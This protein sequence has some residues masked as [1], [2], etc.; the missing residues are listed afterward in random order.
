[1][2]QNPSTISRRGLI[3]GLGAAGGAI[4][5]G[6]VAPASAAPASGSPRSAAAAPRP[7]MQRDTP[8][9]G[10]APISSAPQF[11]VSYQ[12]RC[13][14]DFFPE[15]DLAYGRKFG[16]GGFYTNVNDDY[17]AATF[18]L[19]PGATLYDL[20]WYVSNSTVMN[21]Y[22]NV[23]ASNEAIL[24]T[25]WST[26]VPAGSGVTAHRFVIPSTVNG[27]YPHGTRLMVAAG[28]ATNG[29]TLINGVRAG[30]KNAP[31][32]PVLLPTPVRAYDSR[33]AD[34][35]LSSGHSRTISLASYLPDGAA[36]AIVN[37]TVIQTVTSGYLKLYAAGTP[38]PS[39]STVNWF[40]T[41]QSI[42]NQSTTAV[43]LDRSVT[44]T[45]GG[46]HSTQFVLDVVGYLV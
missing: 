24:N 20:E 27:P 25:F 11:G 36:G 26:S 32:T 23:W 4:A 19:P 30:F 17:L 3:A 15:D 21:V 41:G 38:Q 35:P 9:G 14:D 7:Q 5:L 22:A 12:F 8:P 44:V 1:M 28:T 10:I 46:G 45:I 18:D 31:R 16:G 39:T 29:S 34:G 2:D 37:P 42:G 13:W 43:S 33:S 40:G 6:T